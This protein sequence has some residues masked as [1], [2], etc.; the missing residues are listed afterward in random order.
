M[1]LGY[2]HTGYLFALFESDSIA[3]VGV[4]H[5]L[6]LTDVEVEQETIEIKN[7]AVRSEMQGRG[8]G[9]ELIAHAVGFCKERNYHRIIVGTG[10]SSI[11]NLAFY[12]KAGFRFRSIVRDFFTTHYSE[13]IFEHG[14]QCRDMIVLDL[15]L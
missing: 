8:Y 7:I 13:P 11:D 9:K 5:L 3:A 10:N 14:I 2:L 1:V 4:I 15:G 12:Q 6:P